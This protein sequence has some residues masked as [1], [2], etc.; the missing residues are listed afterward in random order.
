MW[1]VDL[2]VIDGLNYLNN[3]YVLVFL[4]GLNRGI[5]DLNLFG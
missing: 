3:V 5:S 4:W 1:K 2:G